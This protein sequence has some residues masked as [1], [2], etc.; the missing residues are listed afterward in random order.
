MG[1]IN[2]YIKS[3]KGIDFL[4]WQYYNL[5]YRRKIGGDK[6]SPRTGRPPVENPKHVKMNIRISAET[7]QDLKEC[8]DALN[9]SRVNVIEK[10]I[11]LVKDQIEK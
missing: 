6:L 4:Q 11:Q 8:A 2:I 3:K 1:E 10:G 5:L 7:A 9:I